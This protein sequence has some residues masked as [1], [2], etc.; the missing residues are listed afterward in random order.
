MSALS[1][2]FTDLMAYALFFEA[3]CAQRSP[4]VSEVR[5]KVKALLDAQEKRVKAG[6]APWEAYREARFAALSWVDELILNSDWPQRGQWH[7]LM[8][9]FYDTL[10][11]GEEFFQRLEGIP[12]EARDVRE[13]YYFCLSLG[14]RGEYALG[15]YLQQL[16]E[17]QH[18]L[19]RQLPAASGDVH[20]K[21]FKWFP[22]AYQP[23]TEGK[24]PALPR[25]RPLWFGL[26]FFLPLLL[27][28][29]YSFILRGAAIRLLARIGGG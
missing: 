5:E 4:S 10:N 2:V 21:D 19:W 18:T 28:F 27:F 1:D 20:Q 7:H 3:T 24:R 16:R 12:P 14:F 29:L 23:P 17:I 15:T 25:V 26:A 6:E 22:E 8:L 11:A 9:E 13:I